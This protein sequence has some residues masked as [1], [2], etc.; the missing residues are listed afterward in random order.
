[1]KFVFH[2]EA[3]ADYQEAAQHYADIDSHLAL[4][5]VEAVEN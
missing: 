4:R 5:F 1:M 3:L 2:T